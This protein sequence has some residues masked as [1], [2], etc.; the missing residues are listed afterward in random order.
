MKNLMAAL[1][2]VSFLA[3]PIVATAQRDVYV[4]PYT[5]QDGTS[6]QGHYRSAPNNTRMDNWSTQ[7]NTNPYTGQPGTQSPYQQPNT[8]NPYHNPYQQISPRY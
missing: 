6:V 5:R 2:F 7:G 1:L 3:V 4:N 8:Y